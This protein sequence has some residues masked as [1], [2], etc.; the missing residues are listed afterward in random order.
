MKRNAA[1]K[2][3]EQVGAKRALPKNASKLYLVEPEQAFVV[4]IEAS[5]RMADPMDA[6]TALEMM[7]TNVRIAA[8]RALANRPE[9]HPDF[10]DI[11]CVECGEEIPAKRLAM[12]KVRC[13]ICQSALEHRNAQRFA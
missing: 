13:T 8:Q 9:S 3:N 12:K 5:E 11:N 4:E 10:D 7:D 2:Q 6:S 1:L